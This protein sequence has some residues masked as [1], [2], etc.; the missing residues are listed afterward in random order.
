MS[1]EDGSE[2][3][4]CALEP[5]NVNAFLHTALFDYF[6][7]YIQSEDRAQSLRAW[8]VLVAVASGALPAHIV[9]I[10]SDVSSFIS[11]PPAKRPRAVK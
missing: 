8:S 4:A 1:E 2:E 6:L 11:D 10:A 5:E 7:S 3:I 9:Q